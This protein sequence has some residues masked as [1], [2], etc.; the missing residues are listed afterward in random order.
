[1]TPNPRP[2]RARLSAQQLALEELRELILIGELPP[3]APIVQEAIAAQFGVSRVPVRE[4]LKILEGEGLVIYSPNHGY[5]VTRL[6][7]EEI[8]EIY[9]I[10]ALLEDE[11]T[12]R[13]VPALTEEDFA[14]L[15]D[16]NARLEAAYAS[17]DLLTILVTNREFHDT[18]YARGGT[19]RLSKLIRVVWDAVEPYRTRYFQEANFHALQIDDH[20]GMIKAARDG[21]VE[22]MLRLAELHRSRAVEAMEGMIAREE[23]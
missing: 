13:A 23:L 3:G 19:P 15:E 22:G 4:A 20:R 1:M 2:K 11:A 12:R 16:A 5:R 6:T 21:D 10:R 8:R 9:R 14:L 18:I 7:S 17:Q